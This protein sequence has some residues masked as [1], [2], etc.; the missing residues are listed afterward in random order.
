MA[1]KPMMEFSGVRSSCDMLARN[2]LFER[3][4]A[5]SRTFVSRSSDVRS[6]TRCSRASVSPSRSW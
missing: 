1:E 4:A 3:S 2:W 5:T 6:A